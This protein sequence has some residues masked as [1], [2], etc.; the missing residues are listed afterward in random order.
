MSFASYEISKLES[1]N[2]ELRE[3]VTVLK[4]ERDEA[5]RT[6]DEVHQQLMNLLAVIHRDGGQYVDEHGVAA[7]LERAHDIVIQEYS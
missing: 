7:A 2:A 1:E 5:N 4:A 3:Q 6:R